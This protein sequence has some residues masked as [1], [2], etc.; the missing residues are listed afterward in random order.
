MSQR[1]KFEIKRYCFMVVGCFAYAMALDLFL[2]PNNIVAGGVTGLA[3]V[4]NLV[5]GVGVGAFSILLNLPILLL[6]LKTQGVPFILRC[7]LTTALLGVFTDLFAFLPTITQEPVIAAIYGGVAQGVAIGLFCRFAVS[8]GGTELLARV[9]QPKLSGISLGNLIGVLDGV[10]VLV[11]SVVLKNPENVLMALIVIFISA[12]VSDLII[13]GMDYAKMCYII[14][15][16]PDEVAETLLQNS[17]RGVT[18]LDGTG[19]YTK[20]AHPML[21]TVIKKQQLT[22][23]RLLVEATDPNAFIIVSETTEVLGNGWSPIVG[24]SAPQKRP[25]K[26]KTQGLPPV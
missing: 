12:R 22:K 24:E 16:R 7:F 23:L 18:R 2:V 21:M 19:M 13:T 15:D 10:V 14:T 20:T 11:G 9:I 25:Q 4:L 26:R 17:P 8:S 1:V 6:G 5:F 3:T